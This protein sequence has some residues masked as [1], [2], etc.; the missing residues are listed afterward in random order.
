MTKL[1]NKVIWG[2]VLEKNHGLFT[3]IFR[4]SYVCI[5]YIIR[6]VDFYFWSWLNRPTAHVLDNPCSSLIC[7]C[8]SPP[9]HRIIKSTLYKHIYVCIYSVC[10]C[11]C[12]FLYIY[13]FI[14]FLPHRER[15]SCIKIN[16]FTT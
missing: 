8:L 9:S 2:R 14:Q 16:R 12:V 13:L 3:C 6:K 10:M 7:A 11:I 1:G 5:K 4:V 15:S